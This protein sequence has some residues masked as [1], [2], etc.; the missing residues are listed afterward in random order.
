MTVDPALIAAATGLLTAVGV[1]LK[2]WHESRSIAKKSDLDALRAIID[3]LQEE[4]AKLRKHGADQDERITKQ[5]DEIEE[6][7]RARLV[8]NQRVSEL[9]YENTQLHQFIGELRE[10]IRRRQIHP[11]ALALMR[12]IPTL[13]QE[14]ATGIQAEIGEGPLY[15]R[16]AR[17]AGI[18]ASIS[19]LVYSPSDEGEDKSIGQSTS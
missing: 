16:A 10:R 13:T 5:S 7:K 14:I 6:L 8:L 12:E 18:A 4:N 1:L 9:I 11:G 19:E 2:S 15:D 3:E 17:L